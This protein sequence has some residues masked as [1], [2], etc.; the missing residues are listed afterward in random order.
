MLRVIKGIYGFLRR[1]EGIS[2]CENVVLEMVLTEREAAVTSVSLAQA[3][4][5]SPIGA[6][7]CAVPALVSAAWIGLAGGCWHDGKHN[8]EPTFRNESDSH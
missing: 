3:G 6:V 5:R 4:H 7:L 1:Q 2:R 8:T